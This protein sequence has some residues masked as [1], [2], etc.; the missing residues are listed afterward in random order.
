MSNLT[1]SKARAVSKKIK[2]QFPETPE[3]RLM[4]AIVDCA[5]TDS[6]RD[7]KTQTDKTER[8]AA[9]AYLSQ[10]IPHCEISGVNSEWVHRIINYAGLGFT[11]PRR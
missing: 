5:I 8:D 1:L 6:I 2:F 9:I 4:F 10:T 11:I 3:G 7:V